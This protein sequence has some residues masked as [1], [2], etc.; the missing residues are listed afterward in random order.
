MSRIKVTRRVAVLL[1]AIAIA[2]AACGG[3]GESDRAVGQTVRVRCD[4][5]HVSACAARLGGREVTLTIQPRPV[6]TMEDLTFEVTV[7]GDDSA[8][9]PYIDLNMAVMDMGPNRVE[10]ISL[11]NGRWKGT[12]V[13]VRCPSGKR[14]W[15][16][17]VTV[18]AV[19]T[20]EFVFDVVH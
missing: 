20:A 6:K 5:I 7:S 13:I 15:V 9:V 3:A 12:G 2:G 4:S 17:A 19:G 11:G 14:T 16:S 8:G 18:P 1:M 10:L